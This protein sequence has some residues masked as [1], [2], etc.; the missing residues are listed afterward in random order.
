MSSLKFERRFRSLLP[1]NP[2][3]PPHSS[4]HHGQSGRRFGGGCGRG[5]RIAELQTIEGGLCLKP[6]GRIRGGDCPGLR[7]GTGMSYQTELS[8]EARLSPECR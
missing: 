4:L 7:S 5:S 8:N 6:L 1:L 3:I 2:S